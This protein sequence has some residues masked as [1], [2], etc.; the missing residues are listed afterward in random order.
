VDT[1]ATNAAYHVGA[2]E[3]KDRTSGT[4]GRAL[5]D[6]ISMQP[7]W[8]LEAN[9]ILHPRE[10]EYDVQYVINGFPVYD[11]RSPAF[12]ASV[13]ADDAESLKVYAGGIPAEFGQKLGGV[14]EINTQRNTS[15][16]LHG[17]VVARCGSFATTSGYASAQYVA[18]RTTGTVTGEGF[19]TD[20]YLD[21]PTLNNFRNHASNSG[22]TGAP[23]REFSDADRLRLSFV[24][25]RTR[26]LVPDDLLQEAVGQRQDRTGGDSEGQL[27]WHI[28]SRRS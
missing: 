11:N 7:G 18:G 6:L 13:G 28:S 4:P 20:R 26:F 5:I 10:S 17:T 27:T 14:V 21:P 8:T 25:R 19:L 1:R 24:Q 3:L 23:E 15:P 16:G 22:F 2:A 12:A 9:G